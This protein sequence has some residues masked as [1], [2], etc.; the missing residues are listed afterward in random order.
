MDLV[1]LRKVRQI[2]ASMVR[3][4]IS[5]CLYPDSSEYRIGLKT[6]NFNA[7]GRRILRA[8]P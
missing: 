2:S 5:A 8:Q 6:L 7:E 1:A 4:D 3:P